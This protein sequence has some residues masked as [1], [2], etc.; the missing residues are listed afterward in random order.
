MEDPQNKLNSRVKARHR[1][2]EHNEMK[3]KSQNEQNSYV[4]LCSN[5][6]NITI[7]PEEPFWEVRRQSG[8]LTVQSSPWHIDSGG[9]RKYLTA[10]TCVSSCLMAGFRRSTSPSAMA[11]FPAAASTTATA[12]I[13]L[14][15]TGRPET[16]HCDVRV[17]GS[18]PFSPPGWP[19]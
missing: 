15:S 1:S 5:N 17:T 8:G 16:R 4:A 7:T 14:A 10:W 18:S 19:R 12:A 3:W 11:S 9:D 2:T 6:K 13:L